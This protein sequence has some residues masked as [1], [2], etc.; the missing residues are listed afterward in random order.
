MSG[1]F[2]DFLGG[3][4]A[5]FMDFWDSKEFLGILRD[6]LGYLRMSGY[7]WDFFEVLLPIFMDFW[8]SKGF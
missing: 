1:D 2:W 6:V 8:D 4:I 7:F 5:I 3:F